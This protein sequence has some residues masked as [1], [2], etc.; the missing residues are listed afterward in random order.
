MLVDCCH[1]AC[2]MVALEC[3]VLLREKTREKKQLMNLG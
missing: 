1:L 2:D 3:A